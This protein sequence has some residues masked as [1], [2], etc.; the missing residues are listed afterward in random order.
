MRH[1]TF[2]G[3]GTDGFVLDLSRLQ[4]KLD[5]LT[6]TSQSRGKIYSLSFVLTIVLFE[7]RANRGL[8]CQR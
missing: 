8:S 6:D 4:G 7:T 1:I 5:Q 2:E 3:I